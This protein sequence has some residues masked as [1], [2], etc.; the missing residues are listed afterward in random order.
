VNILDDLDAVLGLL[1]ACT[2]AIVMA[3]PFV[4]ILIVAFLFLGGY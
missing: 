2:G 3:F 4:F 1:M